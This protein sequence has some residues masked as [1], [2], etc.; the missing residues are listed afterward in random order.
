MVGQTVMHGERPRACRIL[1][2]S[3]AVTCSM[4]CYDNLNFMHGAVTT[5]PSADLI[6]GGATLCTQCFLVLTSIE[7]A[8]Q[9]KVAVLASRLVGLH[10]TACSSVRYTRRTIT[11]REGRATR[12]HTIK[13]VTHTYPEPYLQMILQIRPA[14][15][16]YCSGAGASKSKFCGL[17]MQQTQWI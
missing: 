13:S 6:E 4:R 15:G 11:T 7:S 14:A 8:R 5:R 10:T 16:Q 17:R 3:W 12:S 1:W 9:R 2:Q